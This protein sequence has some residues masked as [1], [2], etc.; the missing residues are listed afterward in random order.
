MMMTSTEL[1]CRI[2]A[3]INALKN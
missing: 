1:S 3:L 2:N